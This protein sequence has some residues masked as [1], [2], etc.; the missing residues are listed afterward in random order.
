MKNPCNLI[1]NGLYISNHGQ[2]VPCYQS[3]NHVSTGESPN[4]KD[5]SIQ[6]YYNSEWLKKFDNNINVKGYDL[7]CKNCYQEEK[8][9][10]ESL[11]QRS[12]N[13]DISRPIVVQ[14]NIGNLCNNACVTCNPYQSSKIAQEWRD[15]NLYDSKEFINFTKE[16]NSSQAL[17]SQWWASDIKLLEKVLADII[18]LNPQKLVLLGGEPTINPLTKTILEMLLP[19][20]PTL[21]IHFT[22]N[23]RIFDQDIVTLLDQFNHY[24]IRLSVDGSKDINEFVRYP[25]TWKE[26]EKISAQWMST[27]GEITYNIGLSAL[28][29]LHLDELLLYL[30]NKTNRVEIWHLNDPNFLSCDSLPKDTIE[31]SINKLNAITLNQDLN[32]VKNYAVN[33]LLSLKLQDNNILQNYLRTICASR[34]LDFD[35]I[36]NLI[37]A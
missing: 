23:C 32:K 4:V 2:L 5:I 7:R 25:G 11:R 18:K 33:H 12:L 9:G 26:F 19:I 15:L 28:T 29:A 34:N 17:N 31:K 21:K 20:S 14:L 27:R 1:Q 3:W 6:E 24:T 22:T 30:N 8:L 37:T 16:F 36:W 10:K 13:E 35:K